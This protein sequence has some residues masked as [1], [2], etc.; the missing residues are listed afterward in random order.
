MSRKLSWSRRARADLREIGDY[1]AADDRAAAER[2]VARLIA[3]AERA[4]RVPTASRRV[5]ELARD[6]IR[7]VLVRSYRIVFRV[8][9]T[10]IEVLTV[11]EGHRQLSLDPESES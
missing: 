7:E 1:I 5:P 10:K 3:A 6:D 2:W 9:A 8:A 11:F 4:S